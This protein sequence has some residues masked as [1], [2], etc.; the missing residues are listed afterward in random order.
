MKEVCI[1]CKEE[2]PIGKRGHV[3]GVCADCICGNCDVGGPTL[4]KNRDGFV[5]FPT[6]KYKNLCQKCF[7]SQ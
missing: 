3:S 4:C 5:F 1:S 2:W 6:C 7:V